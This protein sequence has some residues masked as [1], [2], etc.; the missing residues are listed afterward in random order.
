MPVQKRYELEGLAYQ[1]FV[2]KMKDKL[3]IDY[4][5]SDESIDVALK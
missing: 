5:Q 2:K 4:N 3:K 1:E